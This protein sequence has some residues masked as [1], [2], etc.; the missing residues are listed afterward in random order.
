MTSAVGIPR[1]MRQR[2]SGGS[3]GNWRL[4]GGLGD[5]ASVQGPAPVEGPHGDEDA[6]RR[7]DED[8]GG[9]D[10]AV[11][12]AALEL[13]VD[14]ERQRLGPALDVAGE[15]DRGPELAERPGPGHD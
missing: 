13:V 2:A 8:R 4:A 3:R 6:E 10:R 14:E 12:V 9:G 11:E 15:H 7:E 5:G 1:M